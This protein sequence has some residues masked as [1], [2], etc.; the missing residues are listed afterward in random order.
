MIKKKILAV[1]MS[2]T[3][4]ALA[5]CGHKKQSTATSSRS[6]TA[7]SAKVSSQSQASSANSSSVSEKQTGSN[8]SLESIEPKNVAGAVLTVGAQS[9][10][11]WQNLL[12]SASNGDGNLQVTLEDASGMVTET[13]TGM[14]YSF[15][16]D[17]NN[18]GEINGYTIS[19]DEKTIYLYRE[20]SHG[21]AE[22]TIQPFKTISVQQVV[23][24]AQQSKVQEIGNNTT[25]KEDN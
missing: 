9:D 3:V 1:A 21:S 5:G 12:D 23:K 14:F 11:A 24:A 15:T 20:Q 6:S 22:R 7:T 25:I 8:A 18:G 13:G 19:Q 2:L 17:G 16:L 4:L 10:E